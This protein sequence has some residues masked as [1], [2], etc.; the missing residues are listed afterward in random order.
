MAQDS[1]HA[2]VFGAAGL[3]GW[4]AVN[5]LLSG[6]PTSRSFSRVTA[7]LNRSLPEAE[8]HW[9]SEGPDRPQLQIVSGMDLLQG[10]GDDLAKQ[11]KEK[12]DG[13]EQIT[14]VF[15]FVFAS[16]NEDAVKEYTQNCGMMQRLADALN[17][18]APNLQTFVYSGG[19]RVAY[20]SHPLWN[21]WPT[22][23]QTTTPGQLLTL[24]SAKSSQSPAKDAVGPGPRSDAVVG[25]TPNGSAFSLTLHWAQ[26]LS[27]Y[28]YNHG[29]RPDDTSSSNKYEVEVP[30]PG[31]EAGYQ[32]LLT[33]VSEKILGR[34]AIHAALNPDKCGQKIINMVDNDRPV[35]FA[36]LWP[37]IAN[38]FG[39]KGVGPSETGDALK[40][41]EY[42]TKFRHLFTEN[43]RP[44]GVT[45]GVGAG[46][47]Q[48]DSLGW[49][50]SFHRHLSSERLRGL[51]FTEQRNPVEGWLDAFERFRKAGIIL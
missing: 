45:C 7:V 15:Y 18:V 35:N 20:S 9:P 41:G 28:A 36:E 12:V 16:L 26:Y 22:T 4:S 44:K 19:T 33:P 27:L 30:F 34:I 11:L 29:I 50:L 46:S 42:V 3:L 2:I 17:M 37:A 1:N 21:P 32:S 13:V 8:L 5:Q 38:W 23:S 51:G 39:L 47:A 10:T 31:N 24:G 43:G 48:L 40:P 14:H 49:W 6:Y 25:F